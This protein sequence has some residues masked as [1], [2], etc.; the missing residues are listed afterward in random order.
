M[1]SYMAHTDEGLSYHFLASSGDVDLLAELAAA[2]AVVAVV[3]VVVAA[4]AAAAAVVVAAAV[5]VAV[6]ALALALV[7]APFAG[8]KPAALS[9]FVELVPVAYSVPSV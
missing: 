2:A 5:A 7:L 8:P 9:P 3:V 4:V 1:A 6:P